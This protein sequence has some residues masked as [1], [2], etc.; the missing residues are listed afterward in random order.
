MHSIRPDHRT[1]SAQFLSMSLAVLLGITGC[2][3]TQDQLLPQDGPT[4]QA[5]YRGE[6]D[7]APKDEDDSGD[8]GIELEIEIV[9]SAPFARDDKHPARSPFKRLPNPDLLVFIYP[10]L[11]TKNRVPIPGYATVIPLY[12]RVEY[13]LPGDVTQ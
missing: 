10:H 12:E 1:R 4:M 11:A 9:D 5:I 2:A 6:A 8:L 3:S 7:S 13:R